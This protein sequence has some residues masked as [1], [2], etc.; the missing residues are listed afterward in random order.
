MSKDPTKANVYAANNIPE[1]ATVYVYWT[2]DG[3]T[4][5]GAL[6]YGTAFVP[7]DYPEQYAA[8]DAGA[9]SVV[10][11]ESNLNQY[12]IYL[13][14]DNYTENPDTG[15]TTLVTTGLPSTTMVLAGV[16]AIIAIFIFF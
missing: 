7:E 6:S 10:Y 14:E 2:V 3:R 5:Y 1:D 16:G 4:Q 9:Y 12:H 11:N 13:S 15:E 8:L